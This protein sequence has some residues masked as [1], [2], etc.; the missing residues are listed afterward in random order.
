MPGSPWFRSF[1]RNSAGAIRGSSCAGQPGYAP[2]LSVI[3]DYDINDYRTKVRAHHTRLITTP[4]AGR[5]A[6]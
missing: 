4:T 3:R 2:E 1:A 6:L 5:S